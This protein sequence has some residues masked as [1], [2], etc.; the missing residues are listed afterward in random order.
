MEL[1]IKYLIRINKSTLI[2]G[3]LLL[4]MKFIY[5]QGDYQ[6]NVFYNSPEVQSLF[7]FKE[8][9]INYF[10]GVPEISLELFEIN[11]DIEIPLNLRYH[12]GGLRVNENASWV[13]LG[14]NL[15]VSGGINRVIK[16]LPDDHGWGYLNETVYTPEYA[17]HVCHNN[18][19]NMIISDNCFFYITVFMLIQLT[20]SQMNFI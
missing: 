11:T 4:N 5:S 19:S 2:I 14:W 8:T 16:Q 12:S 17:R 3:I 18:I 9:P 20:W 6:P 1:R 13:G 15:K 10:T 7:K